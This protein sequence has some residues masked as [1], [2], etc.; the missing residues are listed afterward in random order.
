MVGVG[1]FNLRFKLKRLS[2]DLPLKLYL[3]TC[4]PLSKH[5]HC[6]KVKPVNAAKKAKST[7]RVPAPI[8]NSR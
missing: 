3:H 5:P 7:P 6:P 4:Y 2:L 1:T 8:K